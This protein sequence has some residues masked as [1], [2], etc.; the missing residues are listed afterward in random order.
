[1][2]QKVVIALIVLSILS[3]IMYLAIASKQD[4]M[5]QESKAQISGNVEKPKQEA[6]PIKDGDPNRQGASLNLLGDSTIKNIKND[7]LKVG[8]EDALTLSK[9][10]TQ[11]NLEIAERE[12]KRNGSDMSKD[13]I[14]NYSKTSEPMTALQNYIGK[15]TKY[16]EDNYKDNAERSADML[17]IITQD[18]MQNI[19]QVSLLV[20]SNKFSQKEFE[21][22]MKIEYCG[23][24]PPAGYISPHQVTGGLAAGGMSDN[25]S[26][27]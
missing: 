18:M 27:K 15:V 1:M 4:L 8:C 10:T 9:L 7:I 24:R 16:I 25:T 14:A 5:E 23:V 11:I 17:E 21:D 12:S 26:D 2:N 6:A 3:I 20:A 19:V 13:E 22:Y